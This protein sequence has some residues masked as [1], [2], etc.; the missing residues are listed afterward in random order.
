MY[1]QIVPWE[2]CQ[3]SPGSQQ[4]LEG[5]RV[6]WEDRESPFPSDVDLSVIVLDFEPKASHWTDL[7]VEGY[8]NNDGQAVFVRGGHIYIMSDTGKTIARAA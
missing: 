4:I 7:Y 1:V 6:T 8:G 5:K 2:G 3:G